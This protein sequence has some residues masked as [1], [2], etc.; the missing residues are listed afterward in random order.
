MLR[1][2]Q[3][4]YFMNRLDPTLSADQ[5]PTYQRQLEHLGKRFRGEDIPPQKAF[6]LKQQL[7]FF[8]MPKIRIFDIVGNSEHMI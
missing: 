3:L 1:C 6:P 4:A 7:V 8:I 2:E 5:R